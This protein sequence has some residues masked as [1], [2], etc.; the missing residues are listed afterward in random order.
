MHGYKK[1]KK[2]GKY[3]TTKGTQYISSNQ[4]PEMEIY[5]LSDKEFKIITLKKFTEFPE[6]TNNSI[7][8]GKQ[9]MNKVQEKDKES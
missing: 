9:Y 6:N 3:D 5:E 4:A 7:E 2:L 8:S 1:H